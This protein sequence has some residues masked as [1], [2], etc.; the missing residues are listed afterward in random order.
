MLTM[1]LLLLMHFVADFLLQN[2][3][4]ASNK[5]KDWRA[6]VAHCGVYALVFLLLGWSFAVITFVLHVAVDSVTSRI[7]SRLWVGSVSAAVDPDQSY[8]KIDQGAV[9]FLR[10]LETRP[11]RIVDD[12]KDAIMWLARI[13][14]RPYIIVKP[15]IDGQRLH[16]FFVVIGLDQLIH[17]ACLAATYV[18]LFG[19]PVL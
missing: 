19:R 11:A 1:L 4:M 12:L 9:D 3:W 18:Y 16:W 10:D 6:L 15:V 7:T 14:G 2:H 17:A 5:S 8:V 13:A